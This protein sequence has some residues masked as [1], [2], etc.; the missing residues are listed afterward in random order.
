MEIGGDLS[1]DRKK[2]RQES[3]GSVAVYTCDLENS[4]EEGREEQYTRVFRKIQYKKKRKC[5]PFL[6][7]NQRFSKYVLLFST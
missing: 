2:G 1:G 3:V 6:A 7:S 5:V 4:K